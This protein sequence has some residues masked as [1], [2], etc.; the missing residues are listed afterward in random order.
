[1][2]VVTKAYNPSRDRGKEDSKL[3][4]IQE[5]IVKLNLK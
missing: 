3:Q 4:A 1:M 5:F 2:D